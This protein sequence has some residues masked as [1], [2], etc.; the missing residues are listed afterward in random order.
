ML[1]SFLS[2]EAI[3]SFVKSQWL[4]ELLIASNTKAEWSEKR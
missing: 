1:D 4:R 3:E 2:V